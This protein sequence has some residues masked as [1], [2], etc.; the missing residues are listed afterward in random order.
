[1]KWHSSDMHWTHRM[2]FPHVHAVHLHPAHW[3]GTHPVVLAL[4]VT[5]VIALCIIGL[6]YLQ[7]S[8]GI[9]FDL[10]NRGIAYPIM[11]PAVL[12]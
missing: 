12:F 2:H 4:L 11:Y 7:N 6:V 5:G 3:L 10:P 9:R 8:S 1:M